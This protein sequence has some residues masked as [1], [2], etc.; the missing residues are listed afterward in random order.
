M[1]GNV[2]PAL[3]LFWSPLKIPLREVVVIK[4]HD[5]LITPPQSSRN[6]AQ[7]ADT[8]GEW[9]HIGLGHDS[10]PANKY[11]CMSGEKGSNHVLSMQVSSL[12]FSLD[13][14]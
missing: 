12:Q 13:L 14:Y 2:A 1:G 7:G 10:H 3:H 9:T 4:T 5:S 6:T 11:M 8:A